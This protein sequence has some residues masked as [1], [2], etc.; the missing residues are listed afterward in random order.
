MK[1][2][3][4][5]WRKARRGQY[6]ENLFQCVLVSAREGFI[7]Y[8][9]ITTKCFL[10]MLDRSGNKASLSPPLS[11]FSYSIPGHQ[12]DTCSY[13]QELSHI[14]D[15]ATA[16]PQYYAPLKHNTQQSQLHRDAAK[17]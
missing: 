7:F 11:V 1:C 5:H 10:L 15:W 12:D 13:F 9:S 17:Q 14:H 4:F 3:C 2:K 8:S 6:Y 16:G